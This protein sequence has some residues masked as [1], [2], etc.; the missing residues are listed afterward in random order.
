[1]II[2]IKNNRKEIFNHFEKLDPNAQPL[3]GKMGP[4]HVV[5]HLAF[6]ISISN[7][8]GP[9]KQYTELEE[10]NSIKDKLIYT[11]MELPQGVKTPV[12]GDE[13]PALKCSDMNEA[14]SQLKLELESFDSYFKE[15]PN[16]KTIH[17]RMGPLSQQEWTILHGKHIAHH[18]KQFGVK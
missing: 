13:P 1:M 14:I 17:P 11:D 18:L 5:E 12:L 15:N 9:Q 2:D 6:S 8:K 16:G 4:Q 10:G 7:G 3:F